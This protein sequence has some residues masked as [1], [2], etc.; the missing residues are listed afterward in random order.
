[1][2]RS[3]YYIN[4]DILILLYIMNFEQETKFYLSSLI[5]LVGKSEPQKFL[6]IVLTRI[7]IDY[8]NQN[9]PTPI[10]HSSL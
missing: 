10:K 7:L 1:M 2:L 5:R 8:N 9:T 3:K 4:K 6:V